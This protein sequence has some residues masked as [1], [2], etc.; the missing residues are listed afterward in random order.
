MKDST[1]FN[2][3]DNNVEIGLGR[4]PIV[5]IVLI[6]TLSVIIVTHYLLF[7]IIW[8]YISEKAHISERLSQ[9]DIS[10][11]ADSVFHACKLTLIIVFLEQYIHITGI[12]CVSDFTLLSIENE[13]R[14]N[15]SLSWL[16]NVPGILPYLESDVLYEEFRME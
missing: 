13:A 15:S 4:K 9:L 5:K 3:S 2:L 8:L 14:D 1:F 6:V 12:R 10:C 16:W 11:E 7:D